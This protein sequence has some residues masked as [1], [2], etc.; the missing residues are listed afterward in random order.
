MTTAD[1]LGLVTRGPVTVADLPE[2]VG[3][4]RIELIDGSVYVTPLGDYEHQDLVTKYVILINPHL[5]DD[6]RVL[7]GVNVILGDQTLVIPDVAVV[8]PSFLVQRG[9][10]VSPEGLRLAVEITSPSTRRRDLS[11]KRELYRECGVPF[12][13]VDRSTTPFTMHS[14]SNLPPYARVLTEHGDLA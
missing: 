11:L 1:L 2:D 9:L 4:V 6:L 10:G 5:P 7:A 14:D 3:N 13:V 8:D 12:L